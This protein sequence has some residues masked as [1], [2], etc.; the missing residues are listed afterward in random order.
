MK[1]ATM[2]SATIVCAA[3]LA[4]S[5]ATAREV[6]VAQRVVS[7]ADLD[8]N[9]A[10]GVTTLFGRIRTAARAVCVEAVG[11]DPLQAAAR[12]DCSREALATAVNDVD[13][14]QLT[15]Y[16]AGRKGGAPQKIA[17]R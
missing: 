17:R 1:F 7:Y 6:H 4:S 3:A 14:D 8:L 11:R 10:S 12:R 16:Y 9:H 15:A 5:A 13:N 2:I